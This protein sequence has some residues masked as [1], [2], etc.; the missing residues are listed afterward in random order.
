MVAKRDL[1]KAK[2]NGEDLT[3]LQTKL[4]LQI[5]EAQEAHKEY[6]KE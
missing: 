2:Q 4:D 1:D 6:K 3:E 5:N